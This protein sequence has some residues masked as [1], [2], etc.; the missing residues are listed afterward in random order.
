MKLMQKW[1]GKY[2]NR[3]SQGYKSQ[4]RRPFFELKHHVLCLRL[5]NPVTLEAWVWSPTRNWRSMI[6][7]GC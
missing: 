7:E 6:K 4:I 5:R 1:L 2:V 3:T